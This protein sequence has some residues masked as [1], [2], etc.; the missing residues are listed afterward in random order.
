[1]K[2]YVTLYN[3]SA[4]LTSIFMTREFIL[5][6]EGEKANRKIEIYIGPIFFFFNLFTGI[7]RSFTEQQKNDGCDRFDTL[8]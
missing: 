6:R 5:V 7:Y 4:A 3:A 2:Q 1:M 8:I